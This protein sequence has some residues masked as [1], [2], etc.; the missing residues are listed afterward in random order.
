MIDVALTL[1]LAH[2]LNASPMPTV[3]TWRS[4]A[5]RL[6]LTV[7]TA[8]AIGFNRDEHGRPAGLRTNLLVALAACLAMI[9]TNALINS[10]GKPSDSFVVMDTMRLPLG[11]LS[12]IG[13]IGAGAIIKRGEMIVGL[14]TA[15]TLWF[16]TVMGLCFGGGQIGLGFAGFALGFVTLTALKK[17]EY[18]MPRQES[19]TLRVSL[20]GSG[21]DELEI[22]SRLKR[23]G[24]SPTNIFVS[25]GAD[26]DGSRAFEWKIRWNGDRQQNGPPKAI[27][28]LAMNAGVRKLEF[29]KSK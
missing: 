20:S 25:Y 4:I 19:G 3:L 8:G 7:L 13:F 28:D 11:I 27:Q 9:Q 26:R 2:L 14:T 21:L 12:G 29:T 10:S 18:K 24:I 1:D 15:A 5:I 6:A 22:E 23:A 16:V 17:V